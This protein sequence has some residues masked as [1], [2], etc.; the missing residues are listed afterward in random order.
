[1]VWAATAELI[2]SGRYD[3]IPFQFDS[4]IQRLDS[5]YDCYKYGWKGFA[6]FA[7]LAVY[8]HPLVISFRN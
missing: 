8:N 1:M 3:Y 2:E 7:L 4:I 5:M 6:F